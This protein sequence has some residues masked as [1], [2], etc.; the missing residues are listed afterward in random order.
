MRSIAFNT[1]PLRGPAHTLDFRGKV[2]PG[3]DFSLQSLRRED[4]GINIGNGVIQNQG[5]EEFT[6]DGH[7]DLG[8]GWD[9]RGASGL[10]E[11]VPVPRGLQPILPRRYLFGIASVG[12]VIKHWS[13][14]AFD[15]VADRDEEFEN[16][17]SARHGSSSRSSRWSNFLGRDRQILGGLVPVWFSFNSSAGFPGPHPARVSN[18]ARFVA[19][20]DVY[21]ELTTAFISPD[22]TDRQRGRSR[23]RIRRQHR[24]RPVIVDQGMLRSAREVNARADSAG[25]RTNLTSRPSGW[26]ARK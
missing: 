9:A 16:I 6:F 8:D 21:P 15:V 12:F 23:N 1:S 2:T 20:L 18:A 3:T 25:L 13:N 17:D 11:F 10:S 14:Y 26:E 22:S 7:S 19:A 5:G 4:R 24:Q